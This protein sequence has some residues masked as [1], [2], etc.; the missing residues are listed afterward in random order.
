MNLTVTITEL[1]WLC[2]YQKENTQ[3]QTP[4]IQKWSIQQKYK[5]YKHMNLTHYAP[6]KVKKM[7]KMERTRDFN[8]TLSIM[9][10]ETR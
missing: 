4:K 5:I 9:K 1:Y 8:T 10:R 7:T 2:Q 6:Q 3:F